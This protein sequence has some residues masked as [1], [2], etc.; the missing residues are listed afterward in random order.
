[1]KFTFFL[2]VIPMFFN[3]SLVLAQTKK[4]QKSV[5]EA[6]GAVPERRIGISRIQIFASP[7]S[8]ADMATSPVFFGPKSEEIT[9]KKRNLRDQ[10]PPTTGDS[11]RDL[12]SDTLAIYF[13]TDLYSMT[14]YGDV[15]GK[16]RGKRNFIHD[17]PTENPQKMA[18]DTI[19][20]D[21]IDIGCFWKFIPNADKSAYIPTILMKMD[22]YDLSGQAR[23]EISVTLL[24]ADVKTSHFKEAYGIEYDFVMGIKVKDLEDGGVLGNVVADVYLQALNKLLAKGK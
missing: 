10:L 9:Y 6:R 19:F 4:T 24:P 21:A 7:A 22:V 13:K 5:K 3:L 17:L 18:A 23:S 16:A 11:I 14:G 8:I 15:G 12:T 2:L 20:D 1:M